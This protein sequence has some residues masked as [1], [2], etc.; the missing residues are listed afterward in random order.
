MRNWFWH[1][2]ALAYLVFNDT[3][4][5]ESGMATNEEYDWYTDF[6]RRHKANV[7]IG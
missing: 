7:G 5:Q 1:I 6:M 3:G 2:C 4:A